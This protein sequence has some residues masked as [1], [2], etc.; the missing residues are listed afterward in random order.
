MAE[1]DLSTTLNS[2][3]EPVVTPVVEVLSNP[4]TNSLLALILV[5]YGGLVAPKLPNQIFSYIDNVFFK[6]VFL[7][8]IVWTGTHNPVISIAIATAFIAVLNVANDKKPFEN[9]EAGLEGPDTAIY[10]G[11]ANFTVADLIESFDNDQDA[12]LQA[13]LTARVPGDV[14]ITDYYAPLIATYL[15]YYGHKLKS[16]CSPPPED[17]NIG[18]WTST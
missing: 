17:E 2:Y 7:S 6:I 12:L 10:P 4:I 9:F 13:M 16:P 3:I 15:L 18:T 8:L 1:N 14:K 5:V 11:C